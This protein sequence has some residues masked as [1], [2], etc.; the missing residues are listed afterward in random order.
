MRT[1]YKALKATEAVGAD[2]RNSDKP[3]TVKFTAIPFDPKH[4]VSDLQLVIVTEGGCDERIDVIRAQVYISKA[5]LKK[6]VAGA[7]TSYRGGYI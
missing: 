7:D 6:A 1:H 4:L 3:D 2:Y 5:L